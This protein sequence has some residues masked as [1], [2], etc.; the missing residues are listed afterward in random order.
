MTE[1]HEQEIASRTV[2]VDNI[3]QR[4]SFNGK[5]CL[6]AAKRVDGK[7]IK[8]L[9][10]VHTAAGWRIRPIP[11]D[12]ERE[13]HTIPT[14]LLPPHGQQHAGSPHGR[15]GVALPIFVGL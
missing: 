7:G 2:I 3:A 5:S 6:L 11:W 1:F 9:Q 10:F 8:V 14:T 4:V 13:G 12:I 15:T